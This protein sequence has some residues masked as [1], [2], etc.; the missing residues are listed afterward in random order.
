MK[1]SS[2]EIESAAALVV[3]YQPSSDVITNVEALKDQFG[4]VFVLDNG[5][6]ASSE[7]I[8]EGLRQRGAHVVRL[9][10]NVGIAGALNVG[11]RRVLAEGYRWVGLFDQDS[12]V[13]PFYLGALR[14]AYQA[15]PWRAQIGVLAPE[16]VAAENPGDAMSRLPVGL[17]CRPVWTVMSSG[18][19][20][21]T[22]VFETVGLFDERLFIDY[23][24]F[25]FCLRVR[26]GGY[27]ICRVSGLRLPHRLGRARQVGWG[28]FRRVIRSHPAWRY[29]YRTRNRVYL[30]KRYALRLPLWCIMDAGWLVLDAVKAGLLEEHPLDCFRWTL[31][32]LC[33]ALA[34]RT[35]FLVRPPAT[36]QHAASQPGHATVDSPDGRR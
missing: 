11:V 33:D 32:G 36:E 29:Y 14:R 26:L 2:S 5:S 22:N 13:P 35:G 21:W 4:K 6:S 19:V 24:D 20:V 15:C 16:H 7:P 27:K 17:A 18:S 28:P 1:T 23:V 25:E 34:G 31:R 30:Y 9:P 8:F 12:A 10:S 3:T